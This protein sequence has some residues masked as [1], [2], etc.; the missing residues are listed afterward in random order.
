[1]L[2]QRQKNLAVEKAAIVVK[3]TQTWKTIES[4]EQNNRQKQLN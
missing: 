2:G 4:I 3:N 1:M